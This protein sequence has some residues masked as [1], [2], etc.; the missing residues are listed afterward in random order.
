MRTCRC[1]LAPLLAAGLLGPAASE[2]VP[3][4]LAAHART[5]FARAD[6]GQPQASNQFS[7]D[8]A[9][10][11]WG[12]ELFFSARLSSSGTTACVT[13]HVPARDWTDG[14]LVAAG[15]NRNVPTLWN[16]GRSRWYFWD[17]RA[18]SLWNQVSQ[19]LENPAE[20][21][22][23]RTRAVQ[24]LLA[25]PVWA[26]RLESFAGP[27]RQRAAVL[28]LSPCASPRSSDVACQTAWAAAS[29]QARAEIDRLFVVLSKLI[30]TYV[31]MLE[32]PPS[33]FDRFLTGLGSGEAA[34]R[35]SERELHG[36][37]IFVG[38]GKCATCHFGPDL[39]DGE[40]HDI[41]VP[42]RSGAVEQG[43]H[44]GVRQILEH[45]FNL[46]SPY[47]D[48]PD[49]VIHT[50]YLT[51]DSTDWAKFK[52]PTLRRVMHTA[53]YMHQGQIP[54]LE[55]VVEH[56]SSFANALPAGHHGEHFLVPLFLSEEEKQAL[57]AFLKTL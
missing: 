25:E 19:V 38:K 17:G 16:V 45:E 14:R 52:T 30:A 1:L 41:R 49:R 21:D 12:R 20:H 51:R 31:Q 23:P 18:D 56:Y 26:A 22:L 6:V 8:P 47:N 24:T 34:A 46:L 36:L 33:R 43:R 42:P 53:P 29:A 10:V 54:T 3:A 9:A 39:T 44:A 50:R 13:C 55:A 40:F 32:P 4:E 15:G 35:L 27:V 37:R 5:I 57:V 2:P 48:A 28:S 7:G 11:S